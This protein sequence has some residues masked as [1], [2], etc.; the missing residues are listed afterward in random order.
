MGDVKTCSE[1]HLLRIKQFF[2]DPHVRDIYEYHIDKV[3]KLTDPDNLSA[4]YQKV[5]FLSDIGILLW[6]LGYTVDNLATNDILYKVLMNILSRFD[7]TTSVEIE[8]NIFK[9]WDVVMILLMTLP[10]K[11]CESI[12][13]RIGIV[14]RKI[15]GVS[16]EG[17]ISSLS[18]DGTFI[19]SISKLNDQGERIQIDIC[20][21]YCKRLIWYPDYVVED[22]CPQ[23][24]MDANPDWRKDYSDDLVKMCDLVRIEGLW[25][26]SH[27]VETPDGYLIEMFRVRKFDMANGAKPVFL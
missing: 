23:R 27:E 17:L 19:D 8:M 12:G 7:S 20:A 3:Q 22:T 1:D 2:E 14:A 21:T 6:G 4:Y 5:R 18:L 26:E 9:D 10:G 24:C 13:T 11:S 25:C 16:M 15:S